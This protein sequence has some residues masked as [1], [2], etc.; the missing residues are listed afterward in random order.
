MPANGTADERYDVEDLVPDNWLI[1]LMHGIAWLLTV[2]LSALSIAFICYQ[3]WA[4]YVP[5]CRAKLA[6]DKTYRFP[7]YF[8]RVWGNDAEDLTSE[9]WGYLGACAL[10]TFISIRYVIPA[11][12][13][14][15]RA[16]E[17]YK[18]D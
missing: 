18:L 14:A 7:E 12:P 16:A 3:L 15:S 4:L 8:Y 5:Y 9:H 1:R 10:V 17:H 11:H 13:F 2:A 6:G